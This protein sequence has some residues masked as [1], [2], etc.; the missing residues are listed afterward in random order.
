MDML[1]KA[2][3]KERREHG[4]K[5]FPLCVYHN[6]SD[7]QHV[8]D[9][10][11]HEE[12]EFI[13]LV[14]GNVEFCIDA[15]M[16]KL[17]AGQALFIKSGQIHSGRI[18]ASTSCEFYSIVLNLDILDSEDLGDSRDA[19]ISPLIARRYSFPQFYRDDDDQY[20]RYVIS[21]LGAI[22]LSFFEKGPAYELEIVSLLYAIVA[23]LAICGKLELETAIPCDWDGYKKERFKC[24]LDFIHT[25]YKRRITV[26]DMARQVRLSTFHFSRFFKC[27]SGKTPVEY[28]NEYRID[29]ATHLLL[30]SSDKIM[31]IAFECGFPNFSYFIK[32]FRKYRS[33]TP[34]DFRKKIETAHPQNP[35][36]Q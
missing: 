30:T 33:C 7:K 8:L 26:D 4:K 10:H 23:R 12:A 19:Y 35:E 29:Q 11:W 25:N 27:I 1:E 18:A 21:R 17:R 34:S 20:G 16:V 36:G 13:Y 3:I 9:Y 32:L 6:T 15:E 31:D 2:C 24:V 28:L 14:S 5:D 22:A